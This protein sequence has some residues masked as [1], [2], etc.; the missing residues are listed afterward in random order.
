VAVHPNIPNPDEKWIKVAL[1]RVGIT[2]MALIAPE[3][4][5]IWATRQWI[6]ARKLVQKYEG[7]F[8]TTYEI[9]TECR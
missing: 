8:I 7:G 9:K 1:R 4:V 6:N 5:I 3:L 2:I